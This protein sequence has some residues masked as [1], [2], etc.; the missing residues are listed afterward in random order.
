MNVPTAAVI[1]SM[2]GHVM[3]VP[4]IQ[5]E[6]PPAAEEMLAPSVEIF[7]EECFW[8]LGGCYKRKK[9]DNKSPRS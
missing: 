5:S 7:S 6:V 3:V 2:G 8:H 4:S 1:R 9:G